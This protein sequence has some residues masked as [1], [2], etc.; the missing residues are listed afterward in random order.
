MFKERS[1]KIKEKIISP[2]EKI[3]AE[4]GVASSYSGFWI[5]L[6]IVV[7][8]ISLIFIDKFWLGLLLGLALVVY[9]LYL[10][11]AYFYF[12]TDKRAI[13]YFQFFRTELTSIDYQK[14]TDLI[15]RENFL[16]KIFFGSGDLAINTAGAPREEAVFS[17][18]A[19]PHNL[20]RKIDEIKSSLKNKSETNP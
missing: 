7:L 13:F 8:I 2:K 14:I 1:K 15:V 17:H 5:F 18:I 20:K 12:L 10:K 3:V 11:T 6:G 19:N 9:G 4:F 16:E